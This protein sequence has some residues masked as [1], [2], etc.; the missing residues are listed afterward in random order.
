[1]RG[2][3]IDVLDIDRFERAIEKRP[4]LVTRLF[5]QSEIDACSKSSRPARHLAA[6]FCAKEAAVKALS[7]Q[8]VQLS[9]LVVEGGFGQTPRIRLAQSGADLGEVHL[10]LS[11]ERG[12]ASAVVVA[13]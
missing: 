2:V 12:L 4:G 7:L 1:V 3:G 5:A 9:D 13:A 11:H 10:S 6:R 8:G